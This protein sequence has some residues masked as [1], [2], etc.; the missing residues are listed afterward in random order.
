[1]LE[2]LNR[3]LMLGLLR[4]LFFID[5]LGGKDPAGDASQASNAL[6]KQL[7]IWTIYWPEELL[8]KGKL[9]SFGTAETSITRKS[10]MSRGICIIVG[11]LQNCFRCRLHAPMH[12]L[13]ARRDKWTAI[14]SFAFSTWMPRESIIVRILIDQPAGGHVGLGHSQSPNA[15]TVRSSPPW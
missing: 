3:I 13:Y 11:K 5:N 10:L 7:S 15:K 8:F 9:F 12:S 4:K 6:S 14:T 1:M 2:I